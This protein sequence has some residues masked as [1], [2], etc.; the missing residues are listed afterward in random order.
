VP[1]LAF[2]SQKNQARRLQRFLT[3]TIQGAD[4]LRKL[5]NQTTLVFLDWGDKNEP[6]ASE[7][8]DLA[9]VLGATETIRINLPGAALALT[10][11][12][13]RDLSSI[14]DSL[15]S[16]K[17]Q[18]DHGL[19]FSFEGHYALLAEKLVERGAKLHFLEDGLGTYVHALSRTR[20]E[21]PGL[22]RTYYLALRG[23]VAPIISSANGFTIKG[24]AIR[25]VREV[26][27]GTFGKPI[28]KPQLLLEGFRNFDY[29][30]SSFPKLATRLFPTSKH[31]KVEFAL[32]MLDE[33]QDPELEIVKK[34][35]KE[36]D[37]VFIAQAYSFEEKQ[38][39][40][41]F[42]LALGQ[43]QGRLWIKTHPRTSTELLETLLLVTE[44]N[45]RLRILRDRSPAENLI[46]TLHPSTVF[47]LASTTLTYVDDLSPG[48]KTIS[49]A[50]FALSEL[51]NGKTLKSRR[52]A[53]ALSDDR[54]VLRFF[55]EIRQLGHLESE[56]A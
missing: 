26:F 49:L 34:E 41:I 54:Q 43:I 10:K 32:A 53:K 27:W 46:R 50:E 3:R 25:F 42:A 29:C 51:N 33:V 40:N 6:L 23:V 36:N 52:S 31:Q 15:L 11:A 47:G 8:Q 24:L 37:S 55:P 20:V 16:K 9:S 1:S 28:E 39:S 35:F 12:K 18:I 7:F 17:P 2:V 5:Q 14:Y 19:M 38:L 44:Q 21:I 13:Y 56:I 45:P 30:Y 4:L 48:S 22:F